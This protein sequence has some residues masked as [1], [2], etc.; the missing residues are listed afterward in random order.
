MGLL[1]FSYFHLFSEPMKAGLHMMGFWLRIISLSVLE[2][3]VTKN[4]FWQVVAG[5]FKKSLSARTIDC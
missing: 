4:R 5:T 2:G 3:T 1:Y